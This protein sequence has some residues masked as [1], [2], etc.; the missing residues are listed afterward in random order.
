MTCQRLL[1]TSQLTMAAAMS[2]TCASEVQ[3]NVAI[4][5][6]EDRHMYGM[7][8]LNESCLHKYKNNCTQLSHLVT[9]MYN[10]VWD[11]I[12]S[13]VQQA[14]C[15]KLSSRLCAAAE[16]IYPDQKLTST[17]STLSAFFLRHCKLSNANYKCHCPE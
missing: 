12:P 15:E 16:L 17:K 1:L 8:G 10:I 11:T 2:P 5:H 3:I 9:E 13:S 7:Q 4:N 14:E 6:I